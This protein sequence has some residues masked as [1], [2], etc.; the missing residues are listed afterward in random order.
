MLQQNKTLNPHMAGLQNL[1][2]M[3][4]HLHAPLTMHD[5][6]RWVWL[7]IGNTLAKSMLW[8]VW[9]ANVCG[10]RPLLRD[11]R[12]LGA[13]VRALLVKGKG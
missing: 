3:G 10:G 7:H 9:G 4:K 8:C 2:V 1:L 6:K 12:G 13:T 11:R 5:S